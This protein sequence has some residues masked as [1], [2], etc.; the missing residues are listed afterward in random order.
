MV[1]YLVLTRMLGESYR[2]RFRSLLMCPLFIERYLFP[3]FVDMAQ[4]TE[5]LLPV[6]ERPAFLGWGYSFVGS[7]PRCGKGFF[8]QSQLSVQTLLRCPYI[9]VC[10]HVHKDICAC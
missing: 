9:S 8:S 4:T 1:E 2:G 3:L 6:G 7:I 5:T 10:N